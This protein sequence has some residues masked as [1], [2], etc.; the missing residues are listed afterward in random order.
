MI[1]LKNP[2]IVFLSD[3][4]GPSEGVN[5]GSVRPAVV[6]RQRDAIVVEASASL[7]IESVLIEAEL[8]VI[9]FFTF[10]STVDSFDPEG[11]R[12]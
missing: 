3:A 8:R 7:H 2:V 4:C 5:S 1:V 10:Y 6:G 11:W 9:L 12:K